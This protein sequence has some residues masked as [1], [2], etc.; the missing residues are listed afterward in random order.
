VY[1][2]RI[3]QGTHTLTITVDAAGNVLDINRST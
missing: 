3:S 2:G 1:E